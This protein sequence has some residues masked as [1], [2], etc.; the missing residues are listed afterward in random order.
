[1]LS[2]D[3]LGQHLARMH[4]SA[5]QQHWTLSRI[6]ATPHTRQPPV[7]LMENVSRTSSYFEQYKK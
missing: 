5:M 6:V 1:M 2:Y 7:F 4:N 3:S